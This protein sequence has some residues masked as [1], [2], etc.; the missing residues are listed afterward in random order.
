ML[1]ETGI[2]NGICC[3]QVK[4]PAVC[5]LPACEMQ[6]GAIGAIWLRRALLCTMLLHLSL[7]AATS[8]MIYPGRS[9]QQAFTQTN[10]MDPADEELQ[11]LAPFETQHSPPDADWKTVTS[12][13]DMIDAL[14]AVED[15]DGVTIS[16]F[17]RLS[18]SVT[19]VETTFAPFL[20][21]DT[22]LTFDCQGAMM[23]TDPEMSLKNV[24]EIA[25]NNTFVDIYHCILYG[26]PGVQPL[27]KEIRFNDCRV[28]FPCGVEVRCLRTPPTYHLL[29]LTHIK[30]PS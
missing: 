2:S 12:L 25:Q 15:P 6:R 9:L 7:V 27:A 18:K 11:L 16:T 13:Q 30:L 24:G 28:M 23:Y 20:R 8:D 10:S 5:W 1:V 3:F 17:V 26:P 29:P 22:S 14:D 4:Q 21:P 19:A